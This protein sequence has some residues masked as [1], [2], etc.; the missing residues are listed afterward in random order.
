MDRLEY[1]YNDRIAFTYLDNSIEEYANMKNGEQEGINYILQQIEGLQISIFAREVE[2]GYKISLRSKD[3][4]DVGE[5]A[6]KFDRW[7][8]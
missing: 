7:W 5:L 2:D 8:S 1:F 3:D 6:T 4:I